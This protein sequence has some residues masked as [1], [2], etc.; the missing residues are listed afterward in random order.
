MKEDVMITITGIHPE[1][2]GD[3]PVSVT[4]LGTYMSKDDTVWLTYDEADED[5]H[6][7]KC[8][9]KACPG[10]VT[11][12][13]TGSIV[14]QMFF[15]EG[16]THSCIYETTYG[17]F[18]MNMKTECINIQSSEDRIF[19]LDLRYQ[20]FINGEFTSNCQLLVDCEKVHK[21]HI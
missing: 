10:E 12:Q 9:L 14:T 2:Q 6:V 13:R 5:G 3:E 16:E 17:E 11:M 1:T 20:L 4:T 18:E 21:Y 8:R 7:S 19:S 15:E